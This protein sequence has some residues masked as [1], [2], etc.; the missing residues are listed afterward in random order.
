MPKHFMRIRDLGHAGAWALLDR[1]RRISRAPNQGS[2][3]AGKTAV[4]VF[5]TADLSAEIFAAAVR[6]LGGRVVSAASADGQAATAEDTAAALAAGA[7]LL[8]VS[9][10]SRGGLERLAAESGLP[11]LNAGDEEGDPCR[12]LADLALLLERDEDFARTRVAWMGKANGMA[13]SWIEASIYFPFELFMAVPPGHEPD[14]ALLGLALQAGAKIFLT[15]D[16]RMAAQGAGYLCLNEM[17]SAADSPQ[18]AQSI[19][20]AQTGR[21]GRAA[22][23]EGLDFLSAG[24]PS[25]FVVPPDLAA[26]AA[27]GALLLEGAGADLNPGGLSPVPGADESRLAL[28]GA[29]LEWLLS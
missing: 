8:I 24:A 9:A 28:T 17:G 5:E 10:R 15:Y 20:P 1:A 19:T 25:P 22:H 18:P 3:L 11:V 26:L 16:P 2:C 7:D 21:A 29:L 12:V 4:L 14:R 13:A 27:P 6:S 23:A